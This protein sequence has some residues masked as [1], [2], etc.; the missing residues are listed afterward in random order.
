M[1]T[2]YGSLPF[3]QQIEFFR[4]KI[5]MPTQSWTDL[6]HGMHDRAFVVAGAMRDDLLADLR[7][8]VDKAISKGT[9]LAEF[10]KDFDALV[11]RHGWTYNGGRNWRTRVI[12][13]TNL[14]QSYNAGREAQMM[15]PELR[16][17]RPYGLYKHGGSLSPRQ[18]HL[19]WDGTVLPLDDPW[20]QTHTPSNGWG[21]HCLKFMVSDRDVERMG[22]R[23]ATEAPP[24]NYH[25]VTVGQRGPTPRTVMVPEGIDPGFAYNPGT[26]GWAAVG[27]N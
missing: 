13:D 11:E 10:R 1:A 25:E 12:Y 27:N 15:D 21:C 7:S 4:Q 9:T 26:S 16:K 23:V 19:A 8:A 20:W 14:R 5:T 3:A 18:E 17:A 22:L 24:M 6:W 2:K